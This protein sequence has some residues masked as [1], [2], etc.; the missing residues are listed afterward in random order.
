LTISLAA[1]A[2][3]QAMQPR[4]IAGFLDLAKECTR[5]TR[6]ARSCKKTRMRLSL[7]FVEQKTTNYTCPRSSSEGSFVLRDL[8]VL[9]VKFLIRGIKR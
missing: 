9:R 3:R 2:D 1:V 7:I 8:R 5:G 4:E 6:R